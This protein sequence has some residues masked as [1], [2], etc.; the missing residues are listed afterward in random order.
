MEYCNGSVGDVLEVFKEP[1]A[2]P[3]IAGVCKQVLCA[4]DYL[5]K[6]RKIHRDVKGGNVLLKEDGTAKLVDFGASAVVDAGGKTNSF[7]GTPFWMAPELITAMETG[8]YDCKARALCALGCGPHCAVLMRRSPRRCARQVDVWSLGITLIEMAEIRPPLF[9]MHAM[10]A[11]FHIPQSD[12]PKLAEPHKWSAAFHDFLSKVRPR[13]RMP[14][15]HAETRGPCPDALPLA[16]NC[17]VRPPRRSSRSPTSAAARPT[18]CSSHSWQQS[19]TRTPTPSSRTWSPAVATRHGGRSRGRILRGRPRSPGA[20]HAAR[21]VLHQV[22]EIDMQAILSGLDGL[23]GSD[24]DGDGTETRMTTRTTAG[25]EAHGAGEPAAPSRPA[26]SG[27][28]P[29]ASNEASKNNRL[30][31]NVVLR[32]C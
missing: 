19:T 15:R 22:R 23:T 29:S 26:T 27:S 10:S 17:R 25:A 12:P 13:A 21:V 18:C 14:R 24:N 31:R 28:W 20:A 8:T 6:D 3:E 32:A 4:L 16:C 11:L 2:E 1:L 7:I 30:P 9:K 5:H